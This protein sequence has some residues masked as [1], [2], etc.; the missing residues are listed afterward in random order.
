MDILRSIGWKMQKLL[1]P[2]DRKSGICHRMVPL[3]MLYIMIFTYNFNSRIWKCKYLE[4]GEKERKILKCD[5]YRSLY[6]SSYVTIENG[7]LLELDLSS[8]GQT[9]SCYAFAIKKCTGI[10]WP[11]QD[12]SQHARLPPWSCSWFYLVFQFVYQCD[13]SSFDLINV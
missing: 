9:F 5:F 2:S 6:F 8:E 3:W 1:L 4:N 10:G 7:V 12:F 13:T 11:R